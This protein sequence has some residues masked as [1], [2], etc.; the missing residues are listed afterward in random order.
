M[1]FTRAMRCLRTVAYCRNASIGL[2]GWR[3]R[4]D[5]TTN[6]ALT[7]TAGMLSVSLSTPT[8]HH[9]VLLFAMLIMLLL[10]WIEARRSRSK[11]DR[12]LTRSRCELINQNDE[13]VMTYIGMGLVKCRPA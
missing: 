11:P 6:W 4:L 3:D 1:R 8:A 13:V 9:G 5:R 2:A 10:L 12:G 7:V